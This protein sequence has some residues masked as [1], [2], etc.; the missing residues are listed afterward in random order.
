MSNPNQPSG[1][2][3]G[4]RGRVLLGIW[5]LFLV[6]GFGVALSLEPNPRGYG[7]HQGLGL[8][9]CTFRFLLGIP[10]PSCGMTT[11]FSHF[12]RGQFVR[13]FQANAAG[14]LLAFVCAIQVPWCWLSI[15]RRRLWR[16]DQPEQFLFY[17][18]VV[19]FLASLAT[20][21]YQ[22]SVI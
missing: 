19:L 7:T 5:S 6:A 9:P 18:L 14:F 1:F 10:C 21:G 4:T 3:I 22:L 13:S 8:P 2:P 20:W 11:S 12:I 16:V 15:H 17:L